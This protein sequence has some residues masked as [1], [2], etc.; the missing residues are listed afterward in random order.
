MFMSFTVAPV[1]LLCLFLCVFV[2][3]PLARFV[4][5][6][7]DVRNKPIS[8]WRKLL[9]Y[10]IRLFSRGVYFCGALQWIRVYGKPDMSVPIMTC[11]PHFSFLDTLL[12]VYLNFPSA[13]GRAGSE[14]VPLFGPLVKICQPIIVNRDQ[15]SS[16]T[17]TVHR[18]IDRVKS[19]LRWPPTLLFVEGTTTN[20]TALIKFKPGAF[21]P[22]LPVQPVCLRYICA[23]SY[24]SITWGWKGP[25]VYKLVWLQLCQLHTTVEFHFLPVY[26]PSEEEKKDANLY[27]ENV[28]QL[29][30]SYM[31]LPVSDYS[32]EDAKLMTKVAEHHLPCGVGLIKLQN[33]RKKYK[34]NYTVL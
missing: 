30:S 10:P 23:S 22:G 34:Y 33:L 9:Y 31:K 6:N 29:M 12:F 19:N 4:V 13:V 3:S 7:Q 14:E 28:R 11:A 8:G 20:G 15:Y 21:I 27:A 25:S 18:L 17:D 5:H 24:D 32:Y 1:R 16:R 26:K 2:A